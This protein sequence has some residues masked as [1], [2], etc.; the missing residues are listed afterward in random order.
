MSGLGLVA[1]CAAIGRLPNLVEAPAAFFALFGVA[2]GCHLVGSAVLWNRTGRAVLVFTSVIAGAARLVLLPA[3]PT[4]STDAYRYVWDARVAASGINVY[5]YPPTAEALAP[6]RD[7][8]VFPKLNHRDWRTVYPPLAQAF[9][10][11]VYALAP[12]S[13]MA[14]KLSLGLV[15]AVAAAVLLGVLHGLGLPAGRLAVYA[16]HPLVLVEIWGSGHLDALALLAVVAALWAAL[17]RAPR[18][19]GMLIGV[20]TLVKLYPAALL[21]LLVGSRPIVPL[22]VFAATLTLGCLPLVPLGSEGLGSL[23]RYLS[24]EYFN[25]GLVRSMVDWL[26]LTVAIAGVAVAWIT[27]RPAPVLRRALWLSGIVTILSPNVFPWYAVWIVPML[28]VAASIPWLAFTAT[29]G[30][31]YTFFL[32]EPWAIP[33]WARLVE[34]SPLVLGALWWVGRRLPQLGAVRRHR[35]DK[36]VTSGAGTEV[37]TSGPPAGRPATE[38]RWN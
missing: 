29:V 4:L 6:L 36:N 8:D 28:T 2:F 33:R 1:A 22:A 13:V 35:V 32:Q 3:A 38:E 21:P 34:F 23:P 14:M 10:R 16:W 31:A 17:K 26:P 37:L 27:R 18:L 30:L 11:L 25:P 24:E 12:D 15:E 20:G 5:R 19:A 7:T 9:F